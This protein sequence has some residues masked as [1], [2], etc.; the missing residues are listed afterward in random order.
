MRIRTATRWI[1]VARPES[2]TGVAM[3]QKT[4]PFT[5]PQGVSPLFC[6]YLILGL[7]LWE[8]PKYGSADDSPRES[9]ETRLILKRLAEQEQRIA[10]FQAQLSTLTMSMAGVPGPPAIAP[11][12]RRGEPRFRQLFT[13]NRDGT[14]LRELFAA[15]GMITTTMPNWSHDGKMIACESVA[16]TD[17]FVESRL[18]I[19]AAAGPFK[20]MMR[21]LCAGNTPCF[22]PDDSRIAFMINGGNPDGVEGGAWVINADGT[23]R[24]RL[25]DGWFTRWS[26]NG[27][28]ICVYAHFTQPPSL[29]LYNLETGNERFLLG[30]EEGQEEE[31]SVIFGGATWSPDGEKLVALVERNNEQ[32]LITI[33]MTG[34]RDSIRVIYREPLGDRKFWGPP[35]MS[36]DG[37][38]IAFCIREGKQNGNAP[39]SLNC[40][41]YLVAADGNSEARLLEGRKI[42]TINLGPDW[43]RDGKRVV[44]SSER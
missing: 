44:F 13:I 26:P 32:Q 39:Q 33:D 23:D 29:K 5:K 2:S 18:W 16:R 10:D 6:C 9:A 20:G 19:Y 22:S 7:A 24:V 34:F 43:S 1:W 27:R 35:T 25:G 21:Y 31:I 4:T 28:H 17:V 8:M 15:P 38:E 42:G 3:E 36:P 40:W 12:S 37:A 11:R 30:K 14:D 41:L